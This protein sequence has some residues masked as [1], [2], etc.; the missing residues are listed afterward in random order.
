[1]AWLQLD[2]GLNP[3]CNESDGDRVMAAE[4]FCRQYL[5]INSFKLKSI[6]QRNLWFFRRYIQNPVYVIL[7]RCV[8]IWHFY[9][10]YGL[11]FAGYIVCSSA[12]GRFKLD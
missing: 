4:I 3:D 8:E 10:I 7:F 9:A 11:L 1:M 6:F 5:K 2:F 12:G